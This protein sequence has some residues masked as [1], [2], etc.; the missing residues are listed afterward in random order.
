MRKFLFVF[1]IIVCNN[2]F[3]YDLLYAYNNALKFNADYLQ[4]I[5]QNLAGKEFEVQGRSLLLPQ[6][7]VGGQINENYFA[8]NGL[9]QSMS[10]HQYSWVANLSQ[11]IFD[12]SKFSQYSKSKYQTK[13]ATLQLNNAKQQLM[14]NVT[15]S[16]FDVL[17]AK[18]T[19]DAVKLTKD[20]FY[21]QYIKSQK[22]FDVG[23]VTIADV[24]DAKSGYDSAVAQYLSAQ[25]DYV[26]RK[27]IFY[28]IT[29]LDADNISPLIDVINLQD[30][31]PDSSESWSYMAKNGNINIKIALEQLNMAK[32]DI[33]IA[34][35]G[36]LPVISLNGSYTKLGDS[37]IDRADSYF[38]N[39]A[40]IPGSPFASTTQGAIGIQLSMP[41][42]NGGAISSQVRQSVANYNASMQQLLSTS[43]LT[44]QDT[45]NAYLQVENGASIV[46]AQAQALKSAE[47]KLKS[48]K[49]GYQI[50]LRNSIDLVNSQKNYYQTI[51]NYYQS[52]YQYLL[53]RIQLM[54]LIGKLDVDFL[55][56]INDNIKH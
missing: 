19:L 13:I 11:V 9:N 44:D 49:I 30:L 51:Q 16:Y 18:N 24:N 28:N 55:R 50:G 56:D 2:I 7:A 41:L 5:S 47:L 54:Y 22:S 39:T 46:K 52:Q 27:N 38:S 25:N 4:K 23:T 8:M 14:V 34:N 17:Y 53:N 20:A 31:K 12:F 3:G 15:K 6:V 1:S 32:E 40:N 36:H 45:I 10:Y 33:K 42:Y 21:E 37:N 35:A 43:R 48:D 26:Y 29:G